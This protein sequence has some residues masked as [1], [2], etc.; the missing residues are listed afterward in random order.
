MVIC[1]LHVAM[2]ARKSLCHRGSSHFDAYPDAADKAG[3]TDFILH[4][5]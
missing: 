4:D 2:K 1:Q 5:V 3:N